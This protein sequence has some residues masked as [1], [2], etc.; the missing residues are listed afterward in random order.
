MIFGTNNLHYTDEK[1]KHRHD[2]LLS[3]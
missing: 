1:T 3:Q 2:F